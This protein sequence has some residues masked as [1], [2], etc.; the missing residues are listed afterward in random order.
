M[1]LTQLGLAAG[2]GTVAMLASAGTASAV[3]IDS[4]AGNTNCTSYLGACTTE[5]I[6]VHPAWQDNNPDGTAAVWIS[7]D[8]TG[9]TGGTLAPPNGTPVFNPDGTSIIMTIEETFSLLGSGFLSLKTWADDTANLYLNGVLLKAA[10]FTD[11]TCADNPIGCE[12]DEFFLYEEL[13]VAGNYILTWE[14]FQ[15]GS[16]TTNASNPFGLLYAGS[17]TDTDTVPEPGTLA[18]L[19]MGL[20]GLGGAAMRRRRSA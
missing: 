8:D 16:E 5:A 7:Y 4:A 18:L 3:L 12:D 10:N 6:S 20:L 1:K 19:G 15:F 17:V 14:V 9:H 13:L 11:D 2:V